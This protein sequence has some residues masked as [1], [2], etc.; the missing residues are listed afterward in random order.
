[1]A[2]EEIALY[3]L[4]SISRLKF[5]CDFKYFTNGYVDQDTTYISENIRRK[6]LNDSSAKAIIKNPFADIILKDLARS[7]HFSIPN[8]MRGQKMNP[9]LRIHRHVTVGLYYL[10]GFGVSETESSGLYLTIVMDNRG[11]LVH[12]LCNRW[13]E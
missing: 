6:Y 10:V 8:R 2:V 9:V 1:M 5:P 3:H 4:D 13:I 11:N 12:A 7:D